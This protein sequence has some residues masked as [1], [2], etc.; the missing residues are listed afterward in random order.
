MSP[1]TYTPRMSYFGFPGAGIA[2]LAKIHAAVGYPIFIFSESISY[3]GTYDFPNYPLTDF[4]EGDARWVADVNRYTSLHGSTEPSILPFY[5]M[6]Y[7]IL[8]LKADQTTKPVGRYNIGSPAIA[9]GQIS[10]D[11][12]VDP[13][14]L[15]Y[16]QR[17]YQHGGTYY[18]QTASPST[19]NFIIRSAV[20]GSHYLLLGNQSFARPSR[21]RVIYEKSSI[22]D[23]DDITGIDD[24]QTWAEGI[25]ITYEELEKDITDLAPGSEE[26]AERGRWVQWLCDFIE[27]EFKI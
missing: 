20:R 15:D 24:F 21:V 14:T 9:K 12:M 16:M 27:D 26:D 1:I 5:S 18:D 22:M 8:R 2:N 13:M 3:W 25:G 10:N 4:P 19:T 11:T 17:C 7:G 23:R 6:N